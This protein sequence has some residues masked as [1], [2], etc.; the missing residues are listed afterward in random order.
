MI[1]IMIYLDTMVN[2]HEATLNNQRVTYDDILVKPWLVDVA[3][4]SNPI[5]FH[6]VRLVDPYST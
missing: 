3:D 4:K 5:Q 6:I 1:K 2:F